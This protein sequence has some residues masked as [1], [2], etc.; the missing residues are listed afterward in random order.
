[1]AKSDFLYYAG[2]L[3]KKQR[4]KN[5]YRTTEYRKQILRRSEQLFY[6][7]A[8]RMGSNLSSSKRWIG[9]CMV[10]TFFSM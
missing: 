7:K 1:M 8:R 10:M 2:S 3:A 6:A 4:Q 9:I 5:R